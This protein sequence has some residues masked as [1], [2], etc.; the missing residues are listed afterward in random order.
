MVNTIYGVQVTA[1]LELSYFEMEKIVKNLV[2]DWD[3]EGRQL[4]KVELISDGQ[5]VHVCAYEKPIVKV[6][7][8]K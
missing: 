8:R 1:D 6:V 7:L 2:E 4:G 3:W 5:F